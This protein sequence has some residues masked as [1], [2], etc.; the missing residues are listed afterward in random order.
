MNEANKARP[1]PEVAGDAAPPPPAGDALA[2]AE[3]AV[4]ELAASYTLWATQDLARVQAAL[5]KAKAEPAR[6]REHLAEMHR[7]AHSMKGQGGSFGYPLI[8][9]VGQSLCRFVGL[10]N[11]RGETDF[12]VIQAHIDAQRLILEKGVRGD[13]GEAGRLL[14]ERLETLTAGAEG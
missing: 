9:R 13:G 6:R 5:D 14:A 12:P 1:A 3:A 4:A 2:A 8:S 11:E 7:I 10:D